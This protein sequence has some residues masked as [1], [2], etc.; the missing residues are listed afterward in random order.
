M[1]HFGK[2][3]VSGGKP[4]RE[5]KTGGTKKEREGLF[6]QEMASE[7]MLVVLFSLKIM[8]AE[9]VMAK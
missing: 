6:V 4:P 2:K 3:P 1:S 8:K 5:N 7:L 9:K